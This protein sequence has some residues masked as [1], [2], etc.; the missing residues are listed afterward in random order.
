MKKAIAPTIAMFILIFFG[1]IAFNVNN[2]SQ[3]KVKGATTEKVM[4]KITIQ[5]KATAP[6][7]AILKNQKLT[8]ETGKTALDLLHKTTTIQTE[9][10]GK[11]AFVVEINGRKA[12]QQKREFWAFYVNGKQAE[13]G[14]GSYIIKNND[15]IEWKIENY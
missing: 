11:N 2:A 13:L 7:G 3:P 10:E 1:I 4:Q 6:E 12:D 5:Q 9:G 8:I 15:A 14:A